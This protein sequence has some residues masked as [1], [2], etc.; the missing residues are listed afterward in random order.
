MKRTLEP[1]AQQRATQRPNV[2]VTT[3]TATATAPARPLAREYYLPPDEICSEILMLSM[4]EKFNKVETDYWADSLKP[5]NTIRLVTVTDAGAEAMEGKTH[6]FVLMRNDQEWTSR[7]SRVMEKEYDILDRNTGR[8]VP[9]KMLIACTLNSVY[10]VLQPVGR[11]T[12][13]YSEFL[14][15][16]AS[17]ADDFE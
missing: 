11:V 2:A 5:G 13:P 7:L 15:K 10:F 14:Q 8:R 4:K 3:A 6:F 9:T 12:M 16:V 1:E 17:V